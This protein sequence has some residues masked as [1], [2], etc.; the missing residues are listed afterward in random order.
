MPTYKGQKYDN[1][2][3]RTIKAAKKRNALVQQGH[4][5][6]PDTASEGYHRAVIKHGSLKEKIQSR[7]KLTGGK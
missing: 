1:Q 4:R 3:M 7:N 5:L 6:N 2:Q